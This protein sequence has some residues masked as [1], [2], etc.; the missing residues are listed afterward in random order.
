MPTWFCDVRSEM[1]IAKEET[2][3]QFM[4]LHI[5]FCSSKLLRKLGL[6]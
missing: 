3:G 4:L 1:K 5:T 6:V 2:F